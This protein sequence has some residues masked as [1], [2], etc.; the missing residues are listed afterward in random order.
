MENKTK[1]QEL[2]AQI[3]ALKDENRLLQE[4]V[5]FLMAKIYGKKSEKSAP[6]NWLSL[7][8][9]NSDFFKRQSQLKNKSK[10]LATNARKSK[11]ATKKN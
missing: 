4:Q 5:K 7:F 10:A 9:E 2:E 8:D 3:L 1:I 6:E 11:Q